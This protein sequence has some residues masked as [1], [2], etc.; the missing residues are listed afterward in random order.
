MRDDI[1]EKSKYIFGSIFLLSNRL[2]ALVDQEL[3]VDQ[4]TTKQWFLTALLEQFGDDPPTIS[5]VAEA[6]G[7]SHQN[8]KQIALKLQE[9]DFLILEKDEKDRRATR[10]KLTEKSF[11]FWSKR[12]GENRRFI[13]ELFKDLSEEEVNSMYNGAAKLTKKIAKMKYGV[14]E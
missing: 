11:S 5:E 13:I 14:E 8:V 10:L 2:Q 4:I 1:L 3:S 7:S 12:Q 9:K 6:M